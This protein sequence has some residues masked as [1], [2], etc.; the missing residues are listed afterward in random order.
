MVTPQSMSKQWMKQ[1]KDKDPGYRPVYKLL[2]VGN[3]FVAW[4]SDCIDSLLYT[5]IHCI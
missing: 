1:T 5:H 2:G 3:P 4:L